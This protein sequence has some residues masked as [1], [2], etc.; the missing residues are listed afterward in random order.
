[1]KTFFSFL[2]IS[3]SLL[4]MSQPKKAPKM[5]P[6]TT[7]GYYVIA[8][9]DTIRGEVVTN[10]EDVTFF[11]KQFTFKP[12]SGGKLVLLDS[13]KAKAYGYDNK[14]FVNVNYDG[15]DMYVEVLALGRINFYEYKFNGRNSEGYD[16]IESSYFIKDNMAEG[17]NIKLKELKK[18]KTKFYKKELEPYM[19]DQVM[20]WSDL[21]KYVF[22]KQLVI[23]AINEFNKF[24]IIAKPE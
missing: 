21:D 19:K 12:L 11:Y 17:K 16:A 20:I 9:G 8:K 23:N 5:A 1:M 4:V 14:N 15:A 13:K 6:V 22:N 7:T 3:S 24:Y 10:P 18:I 2:L